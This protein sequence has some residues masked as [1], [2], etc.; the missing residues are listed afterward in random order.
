MRFAIVCLFVLLLALPFIF[1]GHHADSPSSWSTSEQPTP[2][3]AGSP[4][5]KA[6]T[7]RQLVEW[8]SVLALATVGAALVALGQLVMFLIQLRLM[9]RNA[10]DASVAANAARDSADVAKTALTELER[11]WLVIESYR[12][13]LRSG[14]IDADHPN[15]WYISFIIKNLGR[16]PALI[17]SCGVHIKD[18]DALPAAPDYTALSPLNCKASMAAGESTETGQVG[19]AAEAARRE[20]GSVARLVV[21]GRLTYRQLRGMTHQTGFAA[22]VSSIMP[23]ASAYMNDTYEFHT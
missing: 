15:N 23:A 14:Q 10:E 19:P 8:T 20:D 13:V 4:A 11:P 6:D 22:E 9:R 21:Y 18:I 2:A 3:A 16:A 7:D 12:V 1:D 5:E 17:E